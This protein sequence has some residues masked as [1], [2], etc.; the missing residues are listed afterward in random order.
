MKNFFKPFF[1]FSLAFGFGLYTSLESKVTLAPISTTHNIS[2]M[3]VKDSQLFSLDKP[4]M[5]KIARLFKPDIFLETGTYKGTTV[6]RAL[7]LFPEIHS[8]ELGNKFYLDAVNK[9]KNNNNVYLYLGDSAAVLPKILPDLNNK[10]IAFWLDG[11]YS[12]GATAKGEQHTP[13]MKEIE[14]IGTTQSYDSILLID[15]IRLFDTIIRNKKEHRRPGYPLV[16]DIVTKINSLNHN[17]NVAVIGD[18]LIAYP[19]NKNIGVSP[20]INA[21]TISR[22]YNGKNYSWNTVLNAEK[23]IAKAQGQERA[24]LRLL[25]EKFYNAHL[26]HV[27]LAYHYALWESL[28]LAGNGKYQES[29]TLLKELNQKRPFDKRI[30]Y[31]LNEIERRV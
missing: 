31:Y 19:S 1:L 17:Y 25:Y 27:G 21:C 15:D 26:K 9:F 13:I 18:I 6:Q 2:L 24:T 5:E 16:Q 4:F 30:V 28:A 7:G 11:H 20:V 12:G 29:Y 14:A 8:I 22:L 3:P 23:I 10:S